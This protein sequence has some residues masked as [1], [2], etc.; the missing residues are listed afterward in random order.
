MSFDVKIAV[1]LMCGDH[2]LSL[3]ILPIV[4]NATNVANGYFHRQ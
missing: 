3:A 1:F 2:W 4:Q